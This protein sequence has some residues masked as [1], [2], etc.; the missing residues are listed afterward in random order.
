[1]YFNSLSDK[2][3]QV[4]LHVAALSGDVDETNDGCSSYPPSNKLDEPLIIYPAIAFLVVFFQK[5][6]NATKSLVKWWQLATATAFKVFWKVSPNHHY[7]LL[8]NNISRNTSSCCRRR[9]V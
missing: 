2:Q 5:A 4:K 9:S 3:L 6:A 1:L 7:N 8:S